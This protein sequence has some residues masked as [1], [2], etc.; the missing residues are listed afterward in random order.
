MNREALIE[1]AAKV[2]RR[3]LGRKVWREDGWEVP[4]I[5]AQQALD[6]FEQAYT[7]T[8]GEQ[9]HTSKPNEAKSDLGLVITPADGEREAWADWS[10]QSEPGSDWESFRAGYRAALRRPVQGEAEWE[11][12]I[13]YSPH[14]EEFEGQ[15]LATIKRRAKYI[16]RRGGHY[17]ASVHAVRR[18]PAGESEPVPDTTGT[19]S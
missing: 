14:N 11:Y 8:D 1:E 13:E 12:G 4:A 7:P 6:L 19:E 2:L 3:A 10:E 15:D 5:D 9:A 16:R 17:S 18:R